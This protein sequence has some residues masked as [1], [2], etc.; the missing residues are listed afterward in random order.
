MKLLRFILPLLVA[1]PALAIDRITLTLTVTNVPVTSNS[2]TINASTR[3]WTNAQSSTTFATNLTG[4]GPA[5]TNLFNQIAANA[6]S[7][8]LILR[9]V[10]TNQIQ[11]I[12]TL[13]GALTASESGN[14]SS[15][16]LSTQSGPSTFTALYPMENIVGTTNRTN[17]ASAL[18]SGLSAYSTNAFATNANALSN[19]I[20]KG[21]S[22]RQHIAS[23]LQ[24]N[25]GLYGV[26]AAVTNGYGTNQVFDSPKTTN[27]VN[28][29][30]AIRS[31]GT[32]GNSFQAGSNALA[33]GANSMAIGNGAVA[34]NQYSTALGTSANATNI[35]TT[36][37]G[38]AATA[39]TN[40][41][42][43]VGSGATASAYGAI[44]IGE[45]TTASGASSIIIGDTDATASEFGS[46]AIG[47][48]AVSSGGKSIAVG[49][50]S[51]ATHTNSTALGYSATTTTTNQ[52]RLGTSAETVSVPGVLSAA[53]QTNSVLRGTNVVN[54]RVDLTAR[55]NTSLVNGY[56]S[57]VVVGTNAYI[58]FSGPS[59]AYTNA[60]FVAPG[61]PQ[62]FVAQFD[63]P[64]LSFTLLNESGLEATPENR[65]LTGTG[66]LLNSTNNPVMATFIY[67]DSASR[68]RVISFR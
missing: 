23:Q 17:Q 48:A 55:A 9:W 34:A 41:A 10:N 38:Y 25:G 8:P 47:V 36:A 60:G 68:M 33:Q 14:W 20:T 44:A 28:Y 42:T 57:G 24:V 4:L 1:F 62:F 35:N 21:V 39:S 65:I 52:I 49:V 29:G 13:G 43:A 19:H 56:N 64:G 30:N 26:I 31:E 54:G 66:A 27:L 50:Q 37:V 67:D 45:G 18:V 46:I 3:Y 11:L 2:L 59:G 40:Y 51:S 32:G 6:Y 15:L 61:G 58:R 12:G 7:G 53:S 63:N 22:P 16:V 5:T